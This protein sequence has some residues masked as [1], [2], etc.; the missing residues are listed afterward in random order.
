MGLPGHWLLWFTQALVLGMLCT[1]LFMNFLFWKNTTAC[2]RPPNECDNNAE[3]RRTS[4]GTFECTCNQGFTGD[5]FTC[6]GTTFTWC[7]CGGGEGEFDP[8]FKTAM[9]SM[10]FA[11]IGNVIFCWLNIEAYQWFWGLRVNIGSW[12]SPGNNKGLFVHWLESTTEQA[13]ITFLC[14]FHLVI[15][16]EIRF[17]NNT[18]DVD[19]TSFILTVLFM[20]N[21]GVQ[22]SRCQLGPRTEQDCKSKAY[23]I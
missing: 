1:T 7:V 16:P 8:P 14:F 19:N 18:P 4:N 9:W 23:I 11:F 13:G 20:E 5:G 22:S 21:E 3:C 2:G 17:F 6:Q 10:K 15:M 12:I